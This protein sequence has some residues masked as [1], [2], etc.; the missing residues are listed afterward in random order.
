M[1]KK[2][3]SR[4]TWIILKQAWN[5]A[6]RGGFSKTENE[7]P[8]L[9]NNQRFQS[10]GNTSWENYR[11][12]LKRYFDV[13]T[14]NEDQA[15]YCLTARYNN[16]NA[17]LGTGVNPF[18][19]IG[20]DEVLIPTIYKYEATH[21]E[22]DYETEYYQDECNDEGISVDYNEEC[23]CKYATRDIY[24]E[25][26]DYHEEEECDEGYDDD[27]VCQEWKDFEIELFWWNVESSVYYSLEENLMSDSCDISCL[28][29]YDAILFDR[30]DYKN[31]YDNRETWDYF[32][33]SDYGYIHD[34]G[35]ED[36]GY[37]V[38]FLL[39]D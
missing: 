5:I 3:V 30:E 7:I 29:D 21:N 14:Y 17:R 27:C 13:N 12:I 22:Q 2:G 32:S 31:E 6:D 38:N 36:I 10:C 33:D 25:K 4:N 23:E 39:K 8:R 15:I 20:A 19:N 35:E 28:E 16:D 18:E 37:E 26:E 9:H 11:G 24:N 1:S 34:W